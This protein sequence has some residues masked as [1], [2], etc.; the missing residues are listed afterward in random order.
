MEICRNKGLVLY[1]ICCPC[2]HPAEYLYIKYFLIYE[3]HFIHNIRIL[4]NLYALCELPNSNTL[5]FRPI[6][7]PNMPLVRNSPLQFTVLN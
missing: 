5:M 3:K 7:Y 1:R 2:F 6:F 4:D